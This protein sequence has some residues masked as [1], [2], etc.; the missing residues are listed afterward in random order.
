VEE[1]L[2]EHL[3][4]DLG[5]AFI[6]IPDG[7]LLASAGALLQTDVDIKMWEKLPR[8]DEIMTAEEGIFSVSINGKVFT[9][10]F[11]VSKVNQWLYVSG[12]P[13]AVFFAQSRKIRA[14]F[15]VLTLLIVFVGLPIAVF[16]VIGIS[17]PIARI[18]NVLKDGVGLSARA[19][20]DPLSF[21]SDSVSELIRH[22]RNL[23]EVIEEQQPLVRRVVLERL[24]RG[25][26][27]N[28]TEAKA[29]L[30]HFEIDAPGPR[31]F[32]FCVVIEGYFDSISPEILREFTIKSTLIEHELSDVLPEECLMHNVYHNTIGVVLSFDDK[33]GHE[34]SLNYKFSK[35][36]APEVLKMF[37]MPS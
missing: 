29:F 31:F 25:E 32:V 23:Q 15:I 17:R 2:R 22:D 24:F 5:F 35:Q 36:Y 28:E 3:A 4:Q 12:M 19:N 21:I 26:F 37:K 16:K 11:I 27:K 18:S 13:E 8:Q 34:G 1:L 33:T 14:V 7:S 30:T 10:S 20:R 9:V 6:R